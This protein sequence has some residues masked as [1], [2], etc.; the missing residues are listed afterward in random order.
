[1]FFPHAKALF[2]FNTIIFPTYQVT[3]S[4]AALLFG[5]CLKTKQNPP[6]PMSIHVQDFI[7]TCFHKLLAHCSFSVIHLDNFD[8]ST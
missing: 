5:S 7:W 2:V 3:G 4:R 1:M 6:T 8:Q